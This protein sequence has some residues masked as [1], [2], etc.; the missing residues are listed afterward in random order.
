MKT[1]DK[2]SHGKAW[3]EDCHE[4][5]AVWKIEQMRWLI[6]Y[7]DGVVEFLEKSPGMVTDPRIVIDLYRT[8]SRLAKILAVQERQP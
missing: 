5:A 7:A 4:C 8:I 6:R 3:T 1:H 2:C